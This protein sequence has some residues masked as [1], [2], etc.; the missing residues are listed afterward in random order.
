MTPADLGYPAARVVSGELG[1][2]IATNDVWRAVVG[3]DIEKLHLQL[4]PLQ[5]TGR[6][7]WFFTVAVVVLALSGVAVALT[8]Q[9]EI[10]EKLV[11]LKESIGKIEGS[12]RLDE[13]GQLHLPPLEKEI[14]EEV[15]RLR[16]RVY[17]MLPQIKLPDLLLELDNWT[18]FLRPFTHL[19]SG[20]AP[21]GEEKLA[22]VAALLPYQQAPNLAVP[23]VICHFRAIPSFSR[24]PARLSSW[25]AYSS[26]WMCS[27][28]RCV[29]SW[30]ALPAWVAS[31]RRSWRWNW[32]IATSIASRVASSGCLLL[33]NICSTG[34]V[35]WPTCTS[36]KRSAFRLRAQP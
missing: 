23:P 6:G 21:V 29:W 16:P 33:E 14:P 22:L 4:G 10:T 18:G 17:S 9:R 25:N 36:R 27:S 19:T 24:A 15:D 11:A 2:R 31:A 1:D 13:K 20:D 12:L 30:W 35:P 3:T 28:I 32:P 8:G 5:A 7:V 26:L 34:S